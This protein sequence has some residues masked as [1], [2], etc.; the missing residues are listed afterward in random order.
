MTS[1]DVRLSVG[2]EV[3]RIAGQ[4][5]LTGDAALTWPN[6]SHAA[7]YPFLPVVRRLRI[8][9]RIGWHTFRHT[10][11]T[12]LRS[13]GAEWKI[14]QELLPRGIERLPVVFDMK[15]RG[16]RDSNP[17]PL[18]ESKGCGWL[19][20]PPK[21]PSTVGCAWPARL[22]NKVAA[23]VRELEAQVTQS[24]MAFGA[25]PECPVVFAIGLQNGEVVD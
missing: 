15:W 1:A 6:R 17:R 19:P 2:V 11:S 10:Y 4:V 16:R 12:L 22:N 13:T 18:I 20:E 8:N 21:T 3:F 23:R 24:W 9:K 7:P 25:S 14:M 5:G